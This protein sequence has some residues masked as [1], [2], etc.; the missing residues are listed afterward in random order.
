MFLFVYLF[1]LMDI[2]VDYDC[3][4]TIHPFPFNRFEDSWVKLHTETVKNAKKAEVPVKLLSK[5]FTSQLF[6][7][8]HV[9]KTSV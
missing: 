8:R 9:V 3:Y 7:S 4:L 5:C 2:S 6:D 1:D